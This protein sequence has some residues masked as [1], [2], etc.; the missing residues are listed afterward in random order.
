MHVARSWLH[1]VERRRSV[2]KHAPELH[3]PVRHREL[4]LQRRPDMRRRVELLHE[5]QY[6]R[7]VR[8]GRAGVL[9]RAARRNVHQWPVFRRSRGGGVLHER[10]HERCRHVRS[11]H[12]RLEHDDHHVR[13]PNGRLH[14]VGHNPSLPV[15]VRLRRRLLH[16]PH[17]VYLGG[18][19]NRR[20]GPDGRDVRGTDH[21]HVDDHVDCDRRHRNERR[22]LRHLRGLHGLARRARNA[23]GANGQHAARHRDQ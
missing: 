8:A 19:R 10:L 6:A 12:G 2:P 3:R 7:L 5:Q 9:V 13:A 18:R 17:R 14:G 16:G 23:C 21:G 11:E 15:G 1:R 20:H 4:H 22:K